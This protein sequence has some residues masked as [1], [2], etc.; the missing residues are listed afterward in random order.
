MEINLCTLELFIGIL[1]ICIFVFIKQRYP[2]M[3]S[4]TYNFKP[5]IYK[6]DAGVHYGNNYIII[7]IPA[8]ICLITIIIIIH[9]LFLWIQNS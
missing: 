9:G 3:C 1:G 2:N 5:K 6:N 7:N 8:I 4:Y